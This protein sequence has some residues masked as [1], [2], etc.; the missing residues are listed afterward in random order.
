[1]EVRVGRVARRRRR[2]VGGQ[3]LITVWCETVGVAKRRSKHL[4]NMPKLGE[5][6]AT[7]TKVS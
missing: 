7:K 3:A 5:I 1:M 4:A 6:G 2:Q